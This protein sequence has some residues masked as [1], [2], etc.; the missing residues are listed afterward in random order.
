VGKGSVPSESATT[1]DTH[2]IVLGFTAAT[3][4]PIMCAVIVKGKTMKL[5]VCNRT[6]CLHHQ[7]WK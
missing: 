2:F 6:G 7:D 5:E 4:E 1:I 3:C